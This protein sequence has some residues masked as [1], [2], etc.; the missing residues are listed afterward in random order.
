MHVKSGRVKEVMWMI[1]DVKVL[2]LEMMHMLSMVMNHVL[3]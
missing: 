1:S 2:M 3:L